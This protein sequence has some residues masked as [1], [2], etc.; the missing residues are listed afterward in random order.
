MDRG[1]GWF[2][3]FVDRP[4]LFLLRAFLAFLAS[5]WGWVN[6]PPVF[7]GGSR[8]YSAPNASW[9]TAAED[10][11]LVLVE[12]RGRENLLPVRPVLLKTRRIVDEIDQEV[13]E[14]RGLFHYAVNVTKWPR[15]GQA[16]PAFP[17]A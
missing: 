1:D 15:Q 3:W 14:R 7:F 4:P 8:H 13:S 2:G 10:V 11:E 16:G 12:A 17:A 9:V 6:R 5:G